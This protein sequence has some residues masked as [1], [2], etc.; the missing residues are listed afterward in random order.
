MKQQKDRYTIA[1]Y[2]LENF[3]AV[4]FEKTKIGWI[5]SNNKKLL[6]GLFNLKSRQALNM[7]EIILKEPIW[8]EKING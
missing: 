6:E 1:F 2:N 3:F 7:K 4:N 8:Y 5:N